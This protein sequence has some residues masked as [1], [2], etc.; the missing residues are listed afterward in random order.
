M[1]DCT[2]SFLNQIDTLVAHMCF[3]LNEKELASPEY[4]RTLAP[5]NITAVYKHLRLS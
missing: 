4:K 5:L 2:D 1:K 3:R